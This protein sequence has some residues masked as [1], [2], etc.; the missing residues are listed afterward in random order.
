MDTALKDKVFLITGASGGIGWATAEAFAAEGA[1]LVLH[2]Y[3]NV[4]SLEDRAATFDTPTLVHGADLRML[5]EVE[6]LIDAAVAQF[7]VIDG[8]VCNAGVW[9]SAPAP[10]Y[11]MTLD[12]WQDTIDTNLTTTFLVL[13]QYFRHLKAA[14]PLTASVVIVGSTAA[15]FGEE[16]HADY[17]ASK[18]AIVQGLTLSLKNEIVR[19]VPDGR[20]NAVCPGWTRTPM[21]EVGLEDREG[22]RDVM[23]TRPLQQIAESEDIA[24]AILYLSSDKLAGHLTGTILPVSG[25]MEGRLLHARDDLA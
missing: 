17:A 5:D 2:A 9:P 14:T 23:Q 7:G 1:R 11:E 22:V 25:G 12:Q 3:R 10:I 16:D 19:L 21:A 4:A 20:V 18:S 15:L 8:V 24:N 13:R 6:R